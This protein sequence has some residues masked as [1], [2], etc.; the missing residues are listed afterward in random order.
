MIKAWGNGLMPAAVWLD[1][2]VF[3]HHFC[4]TQKENQGNRLCVGFHLISALYL[5]S[6]FFHFWEPAPLQ[7]QSRNH[8]TYLLHFPHFFKCSCQPLRIDYRIKRIFTH[9]LD[10]LLCLFIDLPSQWS[11]KLPLSKFFALSLVA[12]WRNFPSE[13][14]YVSMLMVTLFLFPPTPLP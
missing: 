2:S 12:L 13:L 9:V 14:F 4:L 11:S 8:W 7:E 5:G 3:V 1:R 10:I 6:V